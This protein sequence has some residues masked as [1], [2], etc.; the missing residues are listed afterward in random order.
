MLKSVG[1]SFVLLA[2]GTRCEAQRGT[3]AFVT[4]SPAP[5]VTMFAPALSAVTPPTRATNFAYNLGLSWESSFDPRITSYR[6]RYGTNTT[7][8][9]TNTITTT[10]TFCTIS[11][12]AFKPTWYFQAFT[13]Y[14]TNVSEGSNILPVQ[15]PIESGFVLSTVFPLYTSTNGANW[16]TNKVVTLVQTNPPSNTYFRSHFRQLDYQ[17]TNNQIRLKPFPIP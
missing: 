9:F 3:M 5:A 17:W 1:L 6:I 15:P 16:I 10:N 4:P 2:S 8:A 11:N 14:G 7:S 12:L 13:L